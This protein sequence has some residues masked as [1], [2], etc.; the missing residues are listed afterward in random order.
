[1][2]NTHR[3]RYERYG[4]VHIAKQEEH[5][6]SSTSTYQ[7][8]RHMHS[9]CRPNHPRYADWGG[10]GIVVCSRWQSFSAFLVDMG[11]RPLG[12]TIDRI[13]NDGDYELSNCRWATPK[14]QAAN[15]RIRGTPQYKLT[16]G[17]QLEGAA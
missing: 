9:R 3:H 13:D 8:W 15:R 12:T 1:M 16:A 4:D 7:S 10:R 17:G 6:G 2:C 11:E 14:Q 5:G